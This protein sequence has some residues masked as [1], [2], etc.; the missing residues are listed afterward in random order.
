MGKLFAPKTPK[1]VAAAKEP[2][3]PDM[4]DMPT[5]TRMPVASSATTQEQA[6]VAREK[7][8]RRKGRLSTILTDMN[9]GS[10][11]KTLGA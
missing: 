7:T 1:P 6:R 11:G 4:P 10:S 8:L 5:P 9:I 3:M 2:K